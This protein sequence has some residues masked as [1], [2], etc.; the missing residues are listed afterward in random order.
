MTK[1]KRLP[2][3]Q[4]GIHT[5]VITG[6]FLHPKIKNRIYRSLH[7]AV[8][9]GKYYQSNKHQYKR[10]HGGLVINLKQMPESSHWKYAVELSEINLTT[11]SCNFSRLAL[12]EFSLNT[13]AAFEENFH[14]ILNNELKLSFCDPDIVWK[15]TRIDITQDFFVKSDPSLTVRI[16]RYAG[17]YGLSQKR[18]EQHHFV[19]H[20]EK[21]SANWSSPSCDFSVYSKGAEL[22]NRS[23]HYSVSEEDLIAGKN[24]VRFE[25]RLKRSYLRRME[26]NNPSMKDAALD[27]YWLSR[28]FLFLGKYCS[29][30]FYRVAKEFGTENWYR[31]EG[32]A[33]LLRLAFDRNE[34]T[35]KNYDLAMAYL[36]SINSTECSPDNFSEKQRNKIESILKHW[37]INPIIIPDRILNKRELRRFPCPSL[38][39]RVQE[40]ELAENNNFYTDSENQG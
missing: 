19:A 11:L 15:I 4:P 7:T 8:E 3:F 24:R 31:A 14:S 30:I 16:L 28:Y 22:K 18:F 17:A 37:G 6:Y 2:V 10:N 36:N 32:A 40:L 20:N 9:S 33:A 26:Q 38:Y 5:F 29:S 13:L 25:V 23:K 39:F 1:P 12:T 27:D 35:Q 34:I 21:H